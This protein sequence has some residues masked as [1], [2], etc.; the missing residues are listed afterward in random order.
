M[1]YRGADRIRRW[2][3]AIAIAAALGL[4]TAVVVGWASRETAVAGVA[5]PA[6]RSHHASE[7]ADVASQHLHSDSPLD[8]QSTKTAWLTRERPPTWPRLSPVSVWSPLPGSLATS[9]VPPDIARSTAPA[10]MRANR[11]TLT[12]FCIARL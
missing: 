8:H 3:S 1:R 2:Q 4:F 5:L 11:D 9:G 12:Q 10:A 7:Q 6:P